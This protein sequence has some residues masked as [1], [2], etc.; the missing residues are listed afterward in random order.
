MHTV[1]LIVSHKHKQSTFLLSSD[2]KK[3]NYF[4]LQKNR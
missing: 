4:E 1:V 2:N 3:D